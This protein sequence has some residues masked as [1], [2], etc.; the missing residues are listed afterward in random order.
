MLTIATLLW[1]SNE[2]S[3]DFSQ[4][5]DESWVERLYGGFKRNYRDRFRFVVFTDRPRSFGPG[6]DQE[7]I[8]T[9]RPDYSTCIE[10]YKLNEPMILVGLDTVVTGDISALAE[11]CLTKKKIAL[12]RD[13]YHPM[14]ACNGVALVP[15][16]YA[17]VA[18]EHNGENDMVWVRQYPHVYI[19]DEYPGLVRSYKGHVEKHGVGIAKIVYFHGQKKPHQLQHVDWIKKHWVNAEHESFA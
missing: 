15:A 18:E 12:P 17:C 19:D 8:S 14:I 1:D 16:G 11:H 10:P 9:N 3:K 4:C 13:P 2:K 7:S 6:I 5:Y